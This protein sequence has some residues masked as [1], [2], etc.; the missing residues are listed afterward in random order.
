MAWEAKRAIAATNAD[1]CRVAFWR[2][3]TPG[4][5]TRPHS[6]STITKTAEW[7]NIGSNQEIGSHMGRALH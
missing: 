5:N 2:R 7:L 4:H 3:K 6:N 1:P